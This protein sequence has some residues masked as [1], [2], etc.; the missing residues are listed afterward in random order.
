M[1]SM[2]GMYK[3]QGTLR[4]QRLGR[5]TG[6][7]REALGSSRQSAPARS[8]RLPGQR[9]RKDKAPFSQVMG[10][11]TAAPASLCPGSDWQ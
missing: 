4:H 9:S 5:V 3:G 6:V 11:P 7:G 2:A 8:D 1:A 10:G